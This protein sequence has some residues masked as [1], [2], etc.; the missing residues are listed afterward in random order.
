MTL[1]DWKYVQKAIKIKRLN[2]ILIFGYEEKIAYNFALRLSKTAL[3]KNNEYERCN[4]C[5]SCKNFDKQKNTNFKNLWKI[6][7]KNKIKIKE[8]KK[9]FDNIKINNFSSE[10]KILMVGNLKHLSDISFN[11]LLNILEKDSYNFTILFFCFFSD[12]S[13]G[14]IS[15]RSIHLKLFVQSNKFN[16]KKVLILK[17][18]LE[19]LKA[20]EQVPNVSN[21][22]CKIFNDLNEMFDIWL[23]ICRNILKN[24]LLYRYGNNSNKK[25]WILYDLLIKSK[26][27]LGKYK[28][29]HRISFMN[30]VLLKY[31]IL[32]NW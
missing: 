30:N 23:Y 31:V 15:S 4:K 20:M 19:N 25:L 14:S 2:S 10:K 12:I 27:L 11:F 7:N 3:C 6:P 24:S 13:Y 5:L 28:N 32:K 1:D 9:V 21:I 18:N 26:E 29:L 17:K 16:D 22:I 8:V